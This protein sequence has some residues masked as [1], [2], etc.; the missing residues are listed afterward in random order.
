MGI[1]PSTYQK[2]LKRDEYRCIRCYSNQNLTLHHVIHREYGGTDR[3]DN[4]VVL[5]FT[6]H[7]EWHKK[8]DRNPSAKF[9]KFVEPTNEVDFLCG[10]REYNEN[11]NHDR[12]YTIG[13]A[14]QILKSKSFKTKKNV[15]KEQ[16]KKKGKW[17]K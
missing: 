10:M 4:L 13:A 16:A 1:A 14:D 6:C 9:Y 15:K 12:S 8:H 2:V 3:C 11:L 5:C 17:K 7:R